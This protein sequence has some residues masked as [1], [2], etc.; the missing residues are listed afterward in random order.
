MRLGPDQSR[1]FNRVAGIIQAAVAMVW[2]LTC[3]KVHAQEAS[4][5][6]TLLKDNSNV[7][8]VLDASGSMSEPW[9]DTD[10]KFSA[11]RAA[12]I[13]A[14][15]GLPSTTR[16]GAV[17]FGHRRNFDCSDI[18]VLSNPS[19][20][21]ASLARALN[22]ETPQDRGMRPLAD[23]IETAAARLSQQ[24]GPGAIVVLTD[25]AEEC[26]GN[27]CALS[28]PLAQMQIP[29]HLIGLG[30]DAADAAV[31]RCLPSSAGGS[32][33]IAKTG[34]DLGPF[35][36]KALSLSHT[37]NAQRSAAAIARLLLQEQDISVRDLQRIRD[38][39]GRIDDALAALD[40][41][42][43]TF[44]ER[45][46][47]TENLQTG[48]A[49]DVAQDV[50]LI[51]AAAH[52]LR[53]QL[54]SRDQM[55]IRMQD[56]TDVWN[57]GTL[58]LSRRA[59][60]AADMAALSAVVAEPA[61]K[62]REGHNRLVERRAT[63]ET[64]MATTAAQSADL[65]R[66]IN[67]LNRSL[68]QI[69]TRADS[70]QQLAQ[71]I[72][73][74]ELLSD[75]EQLTLEATDQ[76]VLDIIEQRDLQIAELE[77]E[78]LALLDQLKALRAELMTAQEDV[79][80]VQ[81]QRADAEGRVSEA[82]DLLA[83]LQ[84]NQLAMKANWTAE[85]K[86][87][88]SG[89][90]QARLRLENELEKVLSQSKSLRTDLDNSRLALEE[91]QAENLR[92]ATARNDAVT[93]AAEAKVLVSQLETRNRLLSEGLEQCRTG[94][95]DLTQ[96]IASLQADIAQ[97]H[98]LAAVSEP[99]RVRFVLAAGVALDADVTP[100]WSI[101]D[102]STGAQLG[103]GTGVD[104]A[105][106]KEAG[107]Y[108]VIADLD[109][110]LVER[111]FSV[112]TFERADHEFSLDLAQIDLRLQPTK[113]TVAATEPVD[114][115]LFSPVYAMQ[116]RVHAGEATR[117]FLP[118]A[119]YELKAD[120]GLDQW[121]ETVELSAGDA[122]QQA[123]SVDALP[124]ALDLVAGERGLPID[125]ELEWVLR[126]AREPSKTL[127]FQG[128][129]ADLQLSPG[130][131]DV[132][133]AFDGFVASQT[134]FI[135]A[136]D[137]VS[138]P[139]QESVRFNDGAVRLSF[140]NNGEAVPEGLD[141]QWR[142]E[143]QGAAIVTSQTLDG[144]I[145]QLPAG[146]YRLRAQANDVALER[147]FLVL[148]G[149]VTELAPDFTLGQVTLSLLDQAGM[150][151]D[152]GEIEWSVIP[153]PGALGD[154]EFR[155]AVRMGSAT[156]TLLL[157]AGRYRVTAQSGTQTVERLISIKSGDK[158]SFGLILPVE[159]TGESLAQLSSGP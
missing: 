65:H 59:D 56:Q 149:Q 20:V 41:R 122:V 19:A 141:L 1:P 71:R 97:A 153:Q 145:V 120:I 93:E 4:F 43:E 47:L 52:R 94:R 126:D 31:L 5:L 134:V 42:V 7:M 2:L 12:L 66:R 29:V 86:E 77:L 14:T 34:E 112:R 62:L 118:A 131:Y 27:S 91:S 88:A 79:L 57:S 92:L 67:G 13:E 16:S 78:R 39:L 37:A 154:A 148:A 104:L 130:I 15:A 32:F 143:L 129:Q 49:A 117:L 111:T 28:A 55:L 115:V 132:E 105:L 157:P 48:G 38:D 10:T 114:V 82:R 113:A 73:A 110:Q 54:S 75:E 70:A 64:E 101:E 87:A 102:A 151:S 80:V 100:Q 124:V 40:G 6:E 144:D 76:P 98:S 50:A 116:T 21:P 152:T 142:I 127:A 3:G 36:A 60:L 123:I 18:E 22:A 9:T 26:G 156:Q 128:P 135:D 53:D 125:E 150:P 103:D 68:D 74:G 17:T 58:G 11:A 45:D 30:M 108:R 72:E 138:E 85:I 147:D 8:V 84:A 83:G 63:L 159:P 99:D 33:T 51:R 44:T 155:G 119:S 146:G 89:H 96:H 107:Q 61:E 95:E 137:P 139:L 23:A 106:P 109:G 46:L 133:V 90:L 136:T 158:S 121:G 25:G 140:S 69:L 35:I 24:K 81:R